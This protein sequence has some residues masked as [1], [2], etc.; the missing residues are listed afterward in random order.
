MPKY[1]VEVEWITKEVA[2]TYIEVEAASRVDA[3]A[4]AELIAHQLDGW[5]KPEITESDFASVNATPI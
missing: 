5:S 2:T 1:L 4:K 3:C